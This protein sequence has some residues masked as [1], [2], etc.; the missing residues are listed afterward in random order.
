MDFE[1]KHN[2]TKGFTKSKYI[3]RF[4]RK[5][6]LNYIL[7]IIALLIVDIAQTRVPIIVGGVID[8]IEQQNIEL[9]SIKTAIVWLFVIAGIMYA[10]RLIWRYFIFGTSRSI[11]RDIRDE[12]FSHLEKMSAKYYQKHG[13]GEVMAYM[14]NDLEAIRQALA[15]GILTL[16][17]VIALGTIT[18]YNMVTR[19]DPLLTLA[20]VIPLMLIAVTVR[21]S[22][23][24]MFNRFTEKQEAFTTLSDF[25]QEDLSG[26]KV[27]KSF[28]QEDNFISAFEKENKNNY[29]KNIKLMRLQSLMHPFMQLI[30]GLALAVTICYGGYLTIISSI[31][32]GDFTAFI[33]YLGMLVWP[34]IAIG[35]MINIF[36]RGAASLSRVEDILDESVEIKDGENTV[37]I[38]N[39]EGNIK[40]D[41]LNYKYPDTDNY[42]L[43][44]ISFE[45]KRGQTLGIIGRTGSGK[46]TLVNLL[47]R[48]FDPEEGSIYID[49][50]DILNI[51]LKLLRKS[52]GYVPQDNFLFSDTIAS[53]I[54]FGVRN[55][56]M[57]KIHAAAQQAVVHDNIAEFKDG[58][59]TVIGER[60][61]SLSGGQKQRIS[62]ARALIKEPEILILDDSVSA[63][64]T[65]TEEKIL[66]YLKELR[67]NKTNIIIAHRISTIQDSDLIIVLDEGKITEA[68]THEELLKNQGLYHS[69]YEKQLLEKMLNEQD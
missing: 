54:D 4:F 48:I 9:P 18:L 52:I 34:M 26:I 56:D 19:I 49:D 23:K 28:V 21:F 62:I 10:G 61:V 3:R 7:G 55:S 44:N 39:I 29:E 47:L 12:M 17:D 59:D 46:T 69:I 58:Y 63:V 36:S 64:D 68:G 14:T 37:N 41:N 60:G 45:I 22:G 57:D 33:A 6:S 50:T 13:P 15:Q 30:S 25:V 27:I 2:K 20:A 67:S 43:Q 66:H 31:S 65:D 11:E 51:P 32:L 38:D 40:F 16:F 53:N 42:I 35:I 24:E 1:Q 5:Y 8:G